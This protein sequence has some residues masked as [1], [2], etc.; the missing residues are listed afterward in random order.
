[1]TLIVAES[2]GEGTQPSTVTVI[3]QLAKKE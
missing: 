1:V 3:D 2:Y